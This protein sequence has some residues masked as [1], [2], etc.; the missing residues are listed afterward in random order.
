MQEALLADDDI[1]GFYPMDAQFHERMLAFTGYRRLAQVSETGWVHVDRARQLPVPGRVTETLPEHR[2][3]LA[4]LE[5]R[6]AQAAR[7]ALRHHLRQ[8][9]TSLAPTC[10]RRG[11]RG[12]KAKS[13][14]PTLAVT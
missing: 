7:L 8:M 10:S 13:L 2:A 12:L 11:D 14:R 6:D 5:A 1:A 9:M 4:A 3:V